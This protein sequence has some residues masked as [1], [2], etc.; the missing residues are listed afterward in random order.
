MERTRLFVIGGAGFVGREAIRAAVARGWE[1]L[2]LARSAE[3]AAELTA[4]GAVPVR[5]D[6]RGASCARRAVLDLSPSS[7]A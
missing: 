7:A 5:G 1:V 2:A 4:M 6:A 3:R